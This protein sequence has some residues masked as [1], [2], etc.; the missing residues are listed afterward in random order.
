MFL[1]AI[2][3]MLVI[4]IGLGALYVIHPALEAIVEFSL[5]LLIFPILIINFMNKQTV[6]SLFEFEIIKSIFN[7]LGDYSIALLKEIS[8]CIIFFLMW[9]VLVGIPAG[10]FTKNIFLADF[11]RRNVKKR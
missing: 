4:S 10:A 6:N 11:Y 9:I 8:L 3:F 1:K 2:P 7:N 5:G